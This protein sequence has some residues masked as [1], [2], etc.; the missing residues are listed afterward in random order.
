METILLRELLEAVHGTLLTQDVPMDTPIYR[1]ET[2]SRTIH[3]GALFIPLVGERF[4]GH[5]YLNQLYP[6]QVLYQG[7]EY[8][9]GLGCSGRLVQ[10][11]FPDPGR[12]RD[13][14]RRQ[15]YHQG[16][17]RGGAVYQV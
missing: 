16:Y 13:R 14:Q 11:A 5:A 10:G 6:R 17:D 15:D 12:R 7:R 9:A 4:D 8:R 1:V 3:P 2:D